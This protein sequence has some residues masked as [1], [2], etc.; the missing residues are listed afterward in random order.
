MIRLTAR[1]GDGS[2]LIKEDTVRNM[3]NIISY[4]ET[5]VLQFSFPSS[6]RIAGS[7]N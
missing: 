1:D 6:A 3:G 7:M 2:E 5:P 4:R